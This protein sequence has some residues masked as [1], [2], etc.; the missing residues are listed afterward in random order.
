[1]LGVE[2]SVID[3]VKRQVLRGAGIDA[4]EKQN[5]PQHKGAGNHHE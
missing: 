4:E 5:S 3:A 2:F 1:L